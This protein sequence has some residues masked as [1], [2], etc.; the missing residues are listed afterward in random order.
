MINDEYEAI[1]GVRTGTEI[2]V[3]RENLPQ[4]HIDRHKSQIT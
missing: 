3:L 1:G 4:S 2:E